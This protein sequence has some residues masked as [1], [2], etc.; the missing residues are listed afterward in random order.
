MD[1]IP[2]Q[3]QPAHRLPSWTDT[4]ALALLAIAAVALAVF[5]W[6]S[7]RAQEGTAVAGTQLGPAPEVSSASSPIAQSR[8]SVT[9]EG[10]TPGA[11]QSRNQAPTGQ[12]PASGAESEV[13]VD[14]RGGVRNRGVHVLPTGSRVIDAIHAAGGL[15]TG[16]PYGRLNLAEL[17]HDGQQLVVGKQ[18][19]T[20]RDPQSTPSGPSE[21]TIAPAPGNGESVNLNLAT[22][23]QLESLP[24][25]GPVLAER[26]VTWREQNGRFT[27][28]EDLLDVSGIGDK[29]L[30]GLRDSVSV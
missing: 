28:V 1:P 18:L 19:S 3:L 27:S 13:T 22:V 20:A 21:S 2:P 8:S 9:V 16:H 14:V 11:E 6:W 24:G 29:V 10:P 7:G 30:A 15:R 25:I 23:Q 5:W 26:I 4:R 12:P 17:L